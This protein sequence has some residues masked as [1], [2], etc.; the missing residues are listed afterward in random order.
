MNRLKMFLSLFSITNSCSITNDLKAVIS[1]LSTDTFSS[2]EGILPSSNI[3]AFSGICFS[4]ALTSEDVSQFN[5]ENL[6]EILGWMV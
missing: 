5:G 2:N 3:I 4:M 1:L 6:L